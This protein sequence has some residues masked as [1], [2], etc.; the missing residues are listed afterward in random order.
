[1]VPLQ[2]NADQCRPVERA[3]AGEPVSDGTPAGRCIASDCAVWA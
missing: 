3:Y 1:M 2:P